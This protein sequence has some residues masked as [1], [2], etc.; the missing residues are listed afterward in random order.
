MLLKLS[1]NNTASLFLLLYASAH[2]LNHFFA[3]FWW[4]F[5]FFLQNFSWS[6]PTA[7]FV[8][9]S[10]C[11][12]QTKCFCKR[13]DLLFCCLHDAGKCSHPCLTIIFLVNEILQNFADSAVELL[14]RQHRGF[15]LKANLKAP[16]DVIS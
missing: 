10:S 2:T 8:G 12:T 6:V 16:Y 5:G 4:L 7:E 1:F 14:I 9:P 3:S 11:S 13:I 15:V